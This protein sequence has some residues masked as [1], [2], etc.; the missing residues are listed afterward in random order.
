MLKNYPCRKWQHL[1]RPQ[2]QTIRNCLGSLL[3][4]L[5]T[6]CPRARIG[7]P[8]IH[9][10]GTNSCPRLEMSLTDLDWGSTKGVLRKHPCDFAA[11]S[12]RDDEKVLAPALTNP[13]ARDAD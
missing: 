1:L 11:L 7:T 10:P 12:E 8:R 13:C 2:T 6:E 3:C 5:K 4:I 9:D